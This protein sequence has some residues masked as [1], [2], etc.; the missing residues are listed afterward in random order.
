MRTL[1]AQDTTRLSFEGLSENYVLGEALPCFFLERSASQYY[2]KFVY[3]I[4]CL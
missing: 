4:T 3:V 1:L 2:T